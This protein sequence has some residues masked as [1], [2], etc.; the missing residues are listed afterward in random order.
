MLCLTEERKFAPERGWERSLEYKEEQKEREK[1]QEDGE[2]LKLGL[3]RS[4][5]NLNSKCT[6][7]YFV[8]IDLRLLCKPVSEVPDQQHQH[9]LGTG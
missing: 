9:L 5:Q 3:G 7:L 6:L 4:S 2:K 1:R 8:I